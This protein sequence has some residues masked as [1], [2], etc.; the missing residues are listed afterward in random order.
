MSVWDNKVLRHVQALVASH[1]VLRNTLAMF[2]GQFGANALALVFNIYL[3]NKLGRAGYGTLQ[4]SIAF[5]II[6]TV[7]AEYGLQALLVRNIARERHRA[8][9]FFWNS[10]ALKTLLA[11]GAAVIGWLVLLV[12]HHY[13]QYVDETRLVYLLA[14]SAL[15]NAWYFSIAAVFRAHQENHFEALL[16]FIGKVAYVVGGTMLLAWSPW[17]TPAAVA[18]MFTAAAAIQC[19]VAVVCLLVRHRNLPFQLSPPVMTALLKSGW[20]FFSISLF[21]S[22]NLKFD[23]VYVRLFSLPERTGDY[24]AAYN[25]V[26][27]PIIL[28]NA[29]VQS[30]YPALTECHNRNDELFWTRVK[31][32]VRW[33]AA[34][35]FPVLVFMTIEA[36]RMLG[37]VYKREYMAG[38]VILQVLLWGQGLDFFCPFSGHVLYVLNE[39]RRVIRITAVAVATNIVASL[40]LIPVSVHIWGQQAGPVAASVAMFMCLTVMFWGYVVTLRRWLPVSE[41]LKQ[42]AMPLLLALLLAPLLFFGRHYVHVLVS[43]AIF[44]ALYLA[45]VFG[46]RTIRWRDVKLFGV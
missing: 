29:F 42:L 41:Y 26:L 14:G 23:Y 11:V 2:A 8:G 17:R 5:V 45:L 12:F 24:A 16:F 18:A 39:Q 9:E 3:A 44:T 46:T 10:I 37:L 30:L 6:F 34:L 20:M 36:D 40:V 1:K 19:G 38:S 32:A 43:W 15:C 7:L 4:S 33:L 27:A 25:L 13:D 22:L 28:A 35:G 31:T 21:T